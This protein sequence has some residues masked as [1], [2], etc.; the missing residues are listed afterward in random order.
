MADTFWSPTH[1]LRRLPGG[2]QMPR[3]RFGNAEGGIV[4]SKEGLEVWVRAGDVAIAL[5]L[6]TSLHEAAWTIWRWGREDKFL[7]ERRRPPA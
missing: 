3:T 1:E 2:W 6:E 5:G 7:R 4:P